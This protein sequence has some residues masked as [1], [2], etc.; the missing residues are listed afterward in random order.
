MPAALQALRYA[1]D[2][3]DFLIDLQRR[4]GDIFT[5]RF[6]Y[7]GRLVYVTRPDLVKQVFT[8]SPAQMHAGEANATVLEPALGPNS[9]LT[10]DDAPHM[11]QRKLLLPP[12]HGERIE[13]YGEL[14]REV[15]LREMESWP[16]G[17]PFALRP[18]TQRITLAVIMRA[19]FG[20]HDEAAPDPLR[21]ADRGVQPP[22]QRGH[23][24]PL[25]APQP[26]AA[27]PLGEIPPRPR[28]ARRVHLRGDRPAPRRG[29]GRRGRHDD[30]LSLLLEARHDDGSPMSDEELRDEL[31]TVLGAGHETT[32]T[33]LAWAME[34]LLRN[35]EVLARLRESI[36]AGE[37][38]YLEATVK[39]TLR[40]RPVIVDVARKLTA[41]LRDRRL[42]AA[43]RAPTCC[44]RS[45][46]STTATT[47]SPSRSSSAPSASST[48]RP[49]PT[50]GS[51][52]AAACAAASAPPSPN[53]RCGSSCATFLERAE[54]SAP[55]PEP[56]KVKV[57]NITLAP[58]RGT[59]V[60]LDR[61]LQLSPALGLLPAL[62]ELR[63]RPLRLLVALARPARALSGVDQ[64][65]GSASSSSTSRSFASARSICSAS[66]PA[67]RAAFC[68]GLAELCARP[69]PSALLRGGGGGVAFVALALVG[70]PAG[71][72]AAQLAVLA[73]DR[74]AADRLEQGAV[75]G[76]EDDRA[77]EGE[78]RVL[79]RL[80]ALDVEVVGRLVEDQHVGARG[81]EDRQREP[82]LLAAGDVAQRLLRVGAG[83]EEA[84]E[85]VAGLLPAEPGLA[86][87]GVEHRP[88]AGGGVGVLGEVADLDVVAEPD[89][90]RGRLGAAGEGLDQ[91]RL[92]GA[93]GA[94]Q[95]DVLAPFDFELGAREQGPP[96]HLDRR[97]DQF[98][99]DPPGPLRAA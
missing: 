48:A 45:P 56:E 13:A 96:G 43:G 42:R 26:R 99:D 61:P 28:G 74:A 62:E 16:V 79:E 39:E 52:S 67:R 88:L 40:T 14:M 6:P 11:R 34:R 7:F 53:T 76:D 9:V 46:P 60:R 17:E 93:V 24:L 8:G 55:D 54:L 98:E 75:V 5:V 23:R 90:A 29:R 51:R 44:R 15:T 27:Q 2:P 64:A 30:V 59:R 33:G 22:R 89:R 63:D 66:R 91:G 47:S 4:H 1:R 77:L 50:P 94:D 87:R 31:V 72:V 73:D 19:V 25:P 12:F 71:R 58:G 38:D 85:Q 86:L 32:A 57:R 35:P 82:P 97:A 20:V 49:T 65:A 83:E 21:A 81:D 92:A 70:G 41:P 3:L 95:D 84:A 78:K 18:H 36:A 69:P 68:D 37:D 80:A 10:L